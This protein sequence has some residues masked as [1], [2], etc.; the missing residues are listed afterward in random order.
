MPELN[1]GE[2]ELIA[3]DIRRQDINYSHLLD[4]LVDHVCCDIENEMD[5]GLSFDE[6][7]RM[8]KQRFGSGRFREIQVE[9]LFAV[10]SKYRFM[11]S[12]MKISGIAGTILFGVA[13]L[14]KIQHWPGAGILMTLG[15]FTLALIFLPS[16][17]GVLWKE[18][19]NRRRLFL[20]IS[21]FMT[22]FLFIAGTLFKV[23][24]W[25]AAAIMLVLSMA[26]AVFLML[27]SLLLIILKNE[28]DRS[29]RS[30]YIAAAAG[31]LFYIIGMLFKIQHWP[32]A[33]FFTVIGIV[34]LGFI[35][36]PWYTV[37]HW[38]NEQ[39]IEPKYI[40]II[41]A[42]MAII[43]P[44]ALI[45]INLQKDYNDGYYFN[46]D[47]QASLYNYLVKN[48]SS[49]LMF[50]TDTSA[51]RNAE[52]L[53]QETLHLIAKI[54]GICGLM[55]NVPRP[56]PFDVVPVNDLLM[57]GSSKRVEIENDI[58]EYL[59]NIAKLFPARDTVNGILDPS[60]YLPNS[61]SRMSVM[62]ALNSLEL[63]RNSILAVE[64][65]YLHSLHTGHIE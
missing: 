48:N 19:H 34:I 14:L 59:S 58:S 43:V 28:D 5:E 53:H 1:I 38:K 35:V 26:S 47:R 60:L 10:D 62:S 21:V 18:T 36:L 24:H 41:V 11:K 45:N 33:T 64:S 46:R 44:G 49:L 29:K 55:V 32:L 23:Q 39:H 37:H 27:P 50:K 57:P 6:A 8:V 7:Y 20:F 2:I 42:C 15:A 12:T 4:E 30:I 3:R 52:R 56:R 65:G 17:L 22:G 25:P 63:L 31:A 13:A 9:T 51:M 40:F 61:E 54:D 16:A